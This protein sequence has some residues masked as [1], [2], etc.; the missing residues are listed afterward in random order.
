MKHF[1]S[2][3]HG[4]GASLARGAAAVPVTPDGRGRQPERGAGRVLIVGAGPAG[5]ALAYLLARRGVGVTVLEAHHDFARVFRGE[6]LQ[7]SGIDAFRQ[8]GLG[9]QF[10]R[11]PHAEARAFEVY[12]G[13]RL[14]VR[15]DAAGLGRGGA[16]LVSQ[17][18]LLQL[19]ADE[20]G[21]HPGFRLDRGVAVR[22]FLREDGRVVGV[23][24][25]A[26]DG[27]REYRADLVVGADGRHAATRKHSGLH[28]LSIPQAYDVLWLKVPFPD[29]YPDRSTGVFE[30]AAGRAALA[31]PTADGQL[32]VGF[33]IPKG[34]YAA[35]RARGAG[36]WPE[37][38]IGRLPAYLADH[39]RAHR[40]A[41]AGAT[42]LNVVCGRLTEW[43]APGLL[44]IG[45]AA[46]PMSP[47]G[48]QGVNIALRDALVAANHLCPVLA[49][50]G[51]AAAVDAAAKRVRDER[52]PE[53]VAVQRMQQEQARLLFSPDGWSTRLLHRLLPWLIRSGVIQWLRRKEYRL[54]SEGAVPVRLAV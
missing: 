23:R 26:D 43:S 16:R 27:P 49:G 38:L 50:G 7:R 54:M 9:E 42:L 53:V 48:G 6:G 28:E 44:L 30:T 20:A 19:L 18:A 33:V 10:D 15:A 52:W 22:D 45:D 12:S 24:A 41:V 51:D 37:E 36:G 32:Q 25:G 14:V 34:G 3:L 8:M 17:P 31:F 29:G 5:M 1:F 11:L 13:G 4:R 40:E 47:V 35:L 46:H 21:K 39:L 2:R